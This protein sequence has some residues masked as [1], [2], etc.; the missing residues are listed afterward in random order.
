MS[1]HRLRVTLAAAPVIRNLRLRNA[2]EGR[3]VP[4]G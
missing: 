1:N 4:R 2:A 3:L